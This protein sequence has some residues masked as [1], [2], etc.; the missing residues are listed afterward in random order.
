MFE[1][2]LA[3]LAPW[4]GSMTGKQT[5][6]APSTPEPISRAVLVPFLSETL[7]KS[8]FPF[9]NPLEDFPELPAEL[10]A[11]RSCSQQGKAASSPAERGNES[12]FEGHKA[13]KSS[14]GG[15]KAIPNITS[16]RTPPGLGT[17]SW[18]KQGRA[19]CGHFLEL[20]VFHMFLLSSP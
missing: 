11:A 19:L 20:L 5:K 15:P 13:W 1:G 3:V 10:F 2:L 16:S 9:R 18:E 6:A 14:P 17:S 4:D 12:W 8:H 7:K